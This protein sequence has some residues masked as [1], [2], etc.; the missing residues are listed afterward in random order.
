MPDSPNM[1]SQSRSA[2]VQTLEFTKHI[3]APA[4]FVFR[5][6]T[7]YRDDDDRITNSIYH[8]RAKI[9][10]REPNRIVRVITVPGKDL[11]RSTDV[12]IIQLRPPDRWRL[13]KLSWTDD[14]IGS[15]Q[16]TATGTRDTVLK[17]RFRRTWK[18]GHPPDLLRY[19]R[20]FHRV[21]DRY[22]A[23]IEEEFH[24]TQAR[25]VGTRTGSPRPRRH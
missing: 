16:L 24:R 14:E 13:T 19:R 11:N 18:D 22:V 4:R 17:M 12:E 25:I 8:Y 5:W 6:C 20:L 3:R 1:P 9:V 10:L 23:V 15:Y 21:W 7:D 2:V